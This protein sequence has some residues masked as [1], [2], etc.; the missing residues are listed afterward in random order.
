MLDPAVLEPDLDLFLGQ[1]EVGGDLDASEPGKVHVGGE[2]TL[3]LQQLCAGE[4]RT[5]PFTALKLTAA[6]LCGG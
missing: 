4:R 5:H 3:Q 6:V 2:L 1:V